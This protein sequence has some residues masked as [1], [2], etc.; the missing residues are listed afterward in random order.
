MD[1]Q[2]GADGSDFQDK[3]ARD[4]IRLEAVSDFRAIIEDGNCDL[5]GGG[6]A[7]ANSRQRHI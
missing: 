6:N 2:D 5:P 3:L 1:W 4:D 7:S